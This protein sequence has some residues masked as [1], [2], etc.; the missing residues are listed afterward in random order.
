[1]PLMR[2]AEA[3]C[4]KPSK[5]RLFA[6]VTPLRSGN[7]GLERR[8]RVG[9]RSTGG[10]GAVLRSRLMAGAVGSRASANEVAAVWAR[11]S[12]L[13]AMG[14]REPVRSVPRCCGSAG[15]DGERVHVM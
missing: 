14:C 1:V 5:E 10:L 7:Q 3:R 12:L 11:W 4:R 2:C 6:A 9:L 8:P 13:R 15:A